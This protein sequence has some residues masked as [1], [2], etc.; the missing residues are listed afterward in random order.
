MHIVILQYGVRMHWRIAPADPALYDVCPDPGVRF[1]NPLLYLAFD[2]VRSGTRV[3][4]LNRILGWFDG[5]HLVE[6][7]EVAFVVDDPAR[8]RL[9]DEDFVVR[10]LSKAT[11]FGEIGIRFLNALRYFSKQTQIPTSE[12]DLDTWDWIEIDDL[13][14]FTPLVTIKGRFAI[15][16]SAIDTAITHAHVASACSLPAGFRAPIFDSLFIDAVKAHCE[17]DY[18]RAILYAAMAAETVAGAIL[19]GRYE[20]Q[21]ASEAEDLRM[22]TLRQAGGATVRKDPI[23]QRLRER[24]EFGLLLHEAPL[25]LLR[26]SLLVENEALFKE[27][28]TLYTTRNKIVHRGEPPESN[29]A[30]YLAIDLEGSSQAL[31]CAR[32]ILQWFGVSDT[33]PLPRLGFI[34]LSS[35]P[36][37]RQRP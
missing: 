36:T 17:H 35:T 18:R 33:C 29:E 31:L 32:D 1:I 2:S 22:I 10:L 25:Y 28:K 21:L 8:F 7:E 20:A 9:A 19:D 4:P 30:K 26:R 5:T 27:A 12:D 15:A 34:D 16:A 24:D 13:P 14:L 37:C 11:P 6:S 3:P 23:W